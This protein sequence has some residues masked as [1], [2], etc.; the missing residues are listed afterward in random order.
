MQEVAA[1]SDPSPDLQ[2]LRWDLLF[3]A[4][5]WICFGNPFAAVRLAKPAAA[6]VESTTTP[7]VE[8]PAVV[9][10]TLPDSP[11]PKLAS[12]G[13]ED[14]KTTEGTSAEADPFSAAPIKPATSETYVTSRDRK[15]WYALMAAGHGTAVLD[16]WTTRRAISSGYGV[17][18]DP[19]ERPFAN[20]GAVY[21][22]TQVAPSL[23][24]F[25]GHRMLRSSHHWMRRT[26]WIPQATGASLSLGTAIHNYRVV[27]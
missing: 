17:E 7:A 24:D 2:R 23:L 20:S 16:A 9:E 27:P 12:S 13:P 21:L 11:S 10:P 22:S 8:A 18:A 1:S 19:L 15:L 6:A 5:V 4:L 26:W 3:T 14:A 25:V